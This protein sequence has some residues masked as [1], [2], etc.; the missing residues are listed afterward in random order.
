M[1][2]TNEPRVPTQ[3]SRELTP[4]LHIR[5]SFWWLP[6]PYLV[7]AELRQMTHQ[8]SP[9]VLHRQRCHLPWKVTVTLSQTISFSSLESIGPPSMSAGN[10]DQSGTAQTF[11]VTL[12]TA[13]LG[14]PSVLADEAT[15][16]GNWQTTTTVLDRQHFYLDIV[17]AGE[18]TV[19]F[20]A[21]LSSMI[22]DGGDTRS[23]DPL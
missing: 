20:Q 9:P 18:W 11:I 5:P 3:Q 17:A 4:C 1:Q 2:P 8:P 22:S 7:H 13:A 15:A 12:F 10:S 23:P 14:R 16:S 6:S 19:T 21:G